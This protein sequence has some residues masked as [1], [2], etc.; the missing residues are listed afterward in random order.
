MQTFLIGA[1]VGVLVGG[2]IMYVFY[3]KLKAS[4]GAVETAAS[5]IKSAVK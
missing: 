1:G 2:G 3:A 5:S 4:I